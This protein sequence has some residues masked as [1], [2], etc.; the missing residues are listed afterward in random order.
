[1]STISAQ[2]AAALRQRFPEAPPKP[3]AAYTTTELVALKRYG[4]A[5][6]GA[7]LYL[8]AQ[9][10]AAESAG[11][12][13]GEAILATEKVVPISLRD[14]KRAAAPTVEAPAAPAAPT[15]AAKKKGA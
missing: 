2:D 10:A 9:A 11:G 14:E 5:V 7:A 4:P 15:P 1:M 6:I 3:I 8:A 13:H 12:R